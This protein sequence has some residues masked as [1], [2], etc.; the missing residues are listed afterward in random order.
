MFGRDVTWTTS[1][2]RWRDGRA[3]RAAVDR[4]VG[5][6]PS[7]VRLDG[8]FAVCAGMTTREIRAQVEELY[9]VTVSRELI[10]Q[11]TDEI[12][13][14]GVV[15]NQRFIWRSGYP[16]GAGRPPLFLCESGSCHLHTG[17][18][19]RAAT[20]MRFLPVRPG[21]TAEYAG[22]TEATGTRSRRGAAERPPTRPACSDSLMFQLRSSQGRNRGRSSANR[23]PPPECAASRLGRRRPW[24]TILSAGRGIRASAPRRRNVA[25]G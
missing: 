10:S 7:G 24:A 16:D 12:H 11:V 25:S 3:V 13:G 5:T 6:A 14:E 19:V 15:Q 1:R 22:E 18:G 21:I 20:T 23:L 9:G 4:A 2:T 17:C 8:D